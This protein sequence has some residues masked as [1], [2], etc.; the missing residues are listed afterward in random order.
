VV[1]GS[2]TLRPGQESEVWTQFTMHKGMGGPH[3]FIIRMQTN[4]A[5][6]PERLLRVRSL[7]QE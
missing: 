2:T 5:G 4:D 3:L 7:W 6:Q 1:V